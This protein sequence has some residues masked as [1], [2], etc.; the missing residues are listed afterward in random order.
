M[1]QRTKKRS[2]RQRKN[3]TKKTFLFD[4]AKIHPAS[5]ILK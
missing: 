3:K 1:P 4:A 2:K 5:I